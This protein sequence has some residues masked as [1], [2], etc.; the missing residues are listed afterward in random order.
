[1][2]LLGRVLVMPPWIARRLLLR[3]VERGR[4]GKL[5]SLVLDLHAGRTEIEA[6]WLYGAVARRG[7][8]LGITCPVNRRIGTILNG[9][10]ANPQLRELFRDQPDRL[11]R[12]VQLAITGSQG[13]MS[14]QV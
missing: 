13:G 11:I 14:Y 8:S 7:E 6:D 3:Q 9:L 1:V 12:N 4:G 5:P 10:T 2:P